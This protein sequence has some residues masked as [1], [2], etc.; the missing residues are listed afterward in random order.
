MSRTIVTF[1]IE[2]DDP[3]HPTGVTQDTFDLVVD[4]IAAVGGEDIDFRNVDRDDNL[5]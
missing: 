1:E 3:E 4:A 5:A 2:G